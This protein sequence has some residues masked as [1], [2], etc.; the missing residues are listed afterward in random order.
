MKLLLAKDGVKPDSKD[1]DGRTPLSLA[2]A[3]KEERW[4]AISKHQEVVELLLANKSVDVNSKDNIGRT[5]LSWVAD[6]VYQ[7]PF[8]DGTEKKRKEAYYRM[9]TVVKLLLAKDGVNPNS[10]DSHGQ[11]PLSYAVVRGNEAA[12]KLLTP[13]A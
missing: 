2:A 10:K 3:A 4:M 8:F 11:T 5:P 6:W 13:A 1:K 12:I 7:Q 9:E